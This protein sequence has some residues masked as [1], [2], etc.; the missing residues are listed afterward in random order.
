[1]TSMTPLLVVAL[2]VWGGILSFLFVVDRK[3][4][5]LERKVDALHLRREESDS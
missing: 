1:M 2:L 5:S 3:V 4:S